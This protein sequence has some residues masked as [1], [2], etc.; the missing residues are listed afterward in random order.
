MD[1]FSLPRRACSEVSSACGE[2]LCATAGPAAGWVLLE[3]PGPLG[4]RP[5]AQS[6]LVPAALRA[7]L[8]RLGLRLQLIRRPGRVRPAERRTVFLAGRATLRRLLVREPI[9]L[10]RPGA[11]AALAALATGWVPDLGEAWTRPL[12]LACVQGAVDACC[13]RLGRPVAEAVRRLVGDRLWQ[14]SHLGGCRFA[15]NLLC[16]PDGALYGR[17]TPA[18]VPAVVAACEQ[19]RVEPRWFR[20]RTG[21]PRAAQAA[22][23]HLHRATGGY[24]WADVTLHGVARDGTGGHRVRLTAG[25][26]RYEVDVRAHDL[27]PRRTRCPHGHQSS[28]CRFFVAS[29]RT[30]KSAQT[31]PRPA[32]EHGR[33]SMANSRTE[34]GPMTQ[35]M[36]Q[37]HPIFLK[38]AEYLAKG[39]L[40][41]LMQC[42]HPEAMVVRFQDIL[43]GRDEIRGM[44]Q[45]YMDMNMQYLEMLEYTHTDDTI[46]MRGV[47]SVK[48]VEEIGF[49]AY[50][51]KDGLIWRQISGSE[52]GMR[53]WDEVEG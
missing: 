6:P 23:A 36:V 14:T 48:G 44:I 39:D 12:Y 35:N 40:D 10:L 38:Q 34:E 11:R 42:Y 18:A 15:G 43:S 2:P 21:W 30:L 46:L 16:L 20:G 7:E 49:G 8:G 53:N 13:A 9:D 52:G 47:M 27:P 29:V 37:M 24:D 1:D 19:G 26:E 51:L 45:G 3:Q 22:E 5:A 25:D 50:V 4:R 32:P 28:P 17:L 31:D 33:R 41:G